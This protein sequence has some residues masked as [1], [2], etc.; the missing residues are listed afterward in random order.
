MTA[1]ELLQTLPPPS[2][3]RNV[4]RSRPSLLYDALYHLSAMLAVLTC[5]MAHNQIGTLTAPSLHLQ[6]E[7]RG[8]SMRVI[9]YPV[10]PGFNLV[11]LS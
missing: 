2:S 6:S 8:Y 7:Q 11:S 1:W 5:S 10:L 9:G 4:S 3:L